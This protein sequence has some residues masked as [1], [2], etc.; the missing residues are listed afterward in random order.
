VSCHKDEHRGDY[1]RVCDACHRPDTF[2]AAGFVHP[3]TPGFF[4][5]RHAGVACVKCH[6]RPSGPGVAGTVPERPVVRATAPST[7][8]GTCHPDPHLGQVGP[9]C[10]RCHAIDAA[11]FA[12][13]RFAHEKT[14]FP[15]SG[16]HDTVACEKCHPAETRAFPA[17]TGTA[18]RLGSMPS[19]CQACHKDPHLGQ[20]D[21]PCTACHTTSSFRMLT[22]RHGGM[23]DFFGGFHGRLACSSCHKTETG[24]FPAG[25][26][27]A[28]RLKVGRTCAS[29]HPYM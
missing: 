22:Y 2:K 25:R 4:A 14:A 28:M 6:V 9:A 21:R 5:G 8:C 13:V 11:K 19:E 29:C 16:R 1:G 10:D 15:L 20:V 18:K 23:D 26:G 27:T 24:V 12:P 7:A 17:G 3:R